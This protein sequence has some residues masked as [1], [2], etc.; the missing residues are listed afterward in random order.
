LIGIKAAVASRLPV[1]AIRAAAGLW[2][3]LLLDLAVWRYRRAARWFE[4]G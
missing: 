3:A 2:L 1:L 4:R